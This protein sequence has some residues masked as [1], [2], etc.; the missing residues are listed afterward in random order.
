MKRGVFVV[1][2]ALAIGIM[3]Y[4]NAHAD[5]LTVGEKWT[6][7]HEGYVPMRGPNFTLVGNRV[8][9]VVAVRGE[10][11]EKRWRVN[12][13]WGEED[14][15]VSG[16]FVDANR[17]VDRSTGFGDQIVTI[18]PAF[19]LDYLHMEPQE[20]VSLESTFRFS[21]G[22]TLVRAIKAIRVDDE[23]VTVPAGEYEN[24]IRVQIEETIRF[25]GQD[26]NQMTIT[27][28]REQWLHPSV[29]GVVKEIAIT[30]GF[31]GESQ[32]GTSE[33]IAYTKDES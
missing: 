2:G 12:E 8:R 23:T 20:E 27:T 10:A 26:G 31:D 18:E 22:F 28:Q 33:L 1:I 3:A 19:P 21:E 17:L 29:N 15:W 4:G 16:Q 14:N 5:P 32:T 6:Y 30:A 11:D 7:S 25:T 9:E 24:C 13:Q